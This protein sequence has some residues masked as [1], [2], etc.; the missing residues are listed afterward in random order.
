M[1]LDVSS[2]LPTFKVSAVPGSLIL[3]AKAAFMAL[4]FIV[5]GTAAS[6]DCHDHPCL[7][8]AK[9]PSW[10]L[11]HDLDGHWHRIEILYKSNKPTTL[12][13]SQSSDPLHIIYLISVPYSSQSRMI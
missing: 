6:A 7:V 1:D 13:S 8:S 3:S 10:M 4:A 9:Q 11:Q 5:T 2:G 12:N